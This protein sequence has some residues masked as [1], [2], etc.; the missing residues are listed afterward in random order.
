MCVL[1]IY[2]FLLATTT[3]STSDN[4][5]WEIVPLKR[6]DSGTCTCSANLHQSIAT[7]GFPYE[8]IFVSPRVSASPPPLVVFPHGGPH[9]V[10]VAD[11]GVWNACLVSLGYSVMLGKG[12]RKR[13]ERGEKER[14]E[15]RER[16]GE[17]ERERRDI[18]IYEERQTER[19]RRDYV[20]HYK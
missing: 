6:E 15:G 2:S 17:R 10:Y 9:T 5:K 4:I 12:E 8:A 18:E 3:I 16:E 11:F 19:E 13:G 20:T 7:G 1:L 14:R